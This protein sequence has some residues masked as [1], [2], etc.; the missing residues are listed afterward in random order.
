LVSAA[1]VIWI[2]VF[3][4]LQSFGIPDLFWRIDLVKTLLAGI[5]L[6]VLF[7][8]ICFVGFLLETQNGPC[9]AKPYLARTYPLLIVWLIVGLFTAGRDAF[10]FTMM[11]WWAR[12]I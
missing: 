12:Q 6:S 9:A 7:A 1:F 4:G 11:G 3:G 5:F 8:V 10:R 2:V